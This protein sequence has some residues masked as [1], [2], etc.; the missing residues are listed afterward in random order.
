M[1]SSDDTTPAIDLDNPEDK[2]MFLTRGDIQSYFGEINQ[3]LK[4]P[5]NKTRRE[6]ISRFRGLFK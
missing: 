3:P 5:L 6:L 2:M 4:K 1:I